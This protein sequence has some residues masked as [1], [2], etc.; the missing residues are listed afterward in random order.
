M[1]LTEKEPDF[2]KGGGL[3]PAVV[4]DATTGEVLMVAYMNPASWRET[5]RT[6]KATFWSRSRGS[7]WVKGETSGHFQIVR[8][9][10]LDCDADAVLIKVEQ[11][12]GAA[13]HTGHR[14]CFYRRLTDEGWVVDGERYFD[15]EKVY[16]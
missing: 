13:C 3:I 6:K 11:M 9:I 12:G 15:P 2:D 8:E 7:L 14:S 1:V 4:Q 10:R 5:L 16:G